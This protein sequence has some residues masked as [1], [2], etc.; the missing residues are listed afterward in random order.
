MRVGGWSSSC[1]VLL[2]FLDRN[3]GNWKKKNAV[4]LEAIV[5]NNRDSKDLH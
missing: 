4:L 3:L 2:G 5:F 1:Y